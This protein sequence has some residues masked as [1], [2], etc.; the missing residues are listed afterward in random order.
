MKTHI[1]MLLAV[2]LATILTLASYKLYCTYYIDFSLEARSCGNPSTISILY[3]S[4]KNPDAW[5][6]MLPTSC[7]TTGDSN[8]QLLKFNIPVKKLDILHILLEPNRS[9][10]D[11]RNIQFASQNKI[12][13]ISNTWAPNPPNETLSLHDG[14]ITVT[15]VGTDPP[16]L[17]L[18]QSSTTLKGQKHIDWPT[19]GLIWIFSNLICFSL[20]GLIHKDPR[21]EINPPSLW[22][23]RLSLFFFWS[24]LFVLGFVLYTVTNY[25]W[26]GCDEYWSAACGHEHHLTFCEP[27][28]AYIQAYMTWNQR[29]GNCI[30]FFVITAGKVYFDILNPIFLLLTIVAIIKLAT[31]RIAPDAKTSLLVLATFTL[32][33]CA[34]PSPKQTLFL[35]C[36]TCIYT[37]VAPFWLYF[38][39]VLIRGEHR[40][41]LAQK[42]TSRIMIH[43]A[44][45]LIGFCSGMTNECVIAALLLFIFIY[46][47]L[48]RKT[49]KS[50]QYAA[51][52]GFVCGG[53]VFF[54]APALRLRAAS[55]GSIPVNLSNVPYLERLEYWPR[56]LGDLY[57]ATS[58]AWL[59][60]GILTA[61]A[62]IGWCFRKNQR[63]ILSQNIILSAGL[64]LGAIIMSSS[65][66][67]GAVPYSFGHMPSALLLICACITLLNT[68]YTQLPAGR[69]IA[70]LTILLLC[71]PATKKIEQAI[72]FGRQTQPYLENRNILIHRAR[73]ENTIPV[74]EEL[75]F[76]N[77]NE[78]LIWIEDLKHPE[79]RKRAA[80]YYGV[81]E[82]KFAH[83]VP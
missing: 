13:D 73:Q 82:I 19:A 58:T 65:Y 25:S 27:W 59:V 6:T 43:T 44:L 83:D 74:L 10:C 31:G 69:S 71:V 80:Q 81:K 30:Q 4:P 72:T 60:L 68:I 53:I 18:N 3:H 54:A 32:L 51:I 76:T 66:L 78:T 40:F 70:C 35:A 26:P 36:P 75:P 29:L 22:Q 34:V 45:F 21:R 79:V 67:G 48:K 9:A 56:L 38:L 5:P 2:I 52:A 23:K 50:Y 28:D 55:E 12:L 11:L 63:R 57:T 1:R 47:I 61:I 8:F 7:S 42:Q 49:V 77:N 15:P 14:I 33:I 17:R 46:I 24:M 20:L 62:C 37:W 16:R 39:S 64:F 41:D